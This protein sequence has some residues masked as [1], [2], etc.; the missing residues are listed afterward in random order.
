MSDKLTKKDLQAK[1]EEL[2]AEL[3]IYKNKTQLARNYSIVENE[4]NELKQQLGKKMDW[5]RKK[6]EDEQVLESDEESE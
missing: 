5:W 6:V 2:E 1:I 4:N 3:K